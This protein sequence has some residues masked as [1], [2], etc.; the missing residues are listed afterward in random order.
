MTNVFACG[1]C[2]ALGAN[3]NDVLMN[4]QAQWARIRAWKG[5]AHALLCAGVRKKKARKHVRNLAVNAGAAERIFLDNMRYVSDLPDHTMLEVQVHEQLDRSWERV[6][7]RQLS[8]VEDIERDYRAQT[9]QLIE[10]LRKSGEGDESTASAIAALLR[11]EEAV[12][13]HRESLLSDLS[14]GLASKKRSDEYDWR[15]SVQKALEDWEELDFRRKNDFAVAFCASVG[16]RP[17]VYQNGKGYPYKA[18]V[19]WVE[20]A[21]EIVWCATYGRPEIWDV[22]RLARGRLQQ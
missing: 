18:W 10:T 11:A 22:E 16:S 8:E 9:S 2:V 4:G 15:A 12:S 5:V 17:L 6:V 19:T 13:R 21:P 3:P 1:L 14:T 7:Y 20:I